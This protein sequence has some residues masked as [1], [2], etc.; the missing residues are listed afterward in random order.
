[1]DRD[2]L[3]AHFEWFA[4]WCV[5][6]SPLYE[7]LARGVAADPDLL[8]LAAETPEGRSPAHL[9]FAA[10][11]SLLLAGREA[12]LADYYPTVVADARD[13]DDGDP[14]AAFRECCLANADEIR[15]L[16]ATRRTQTNS[17]RRCT[18][19][20]PAFETVSR[21]ASRGRADCDSREPLALVEVGP[22]AGLNL[23]WDRYLYDY[24]PAGRYGDPESV[25][26]IESAVRAGDPPL[27]A[28]FPP[29]ASRVG[30]DVNPLDV[31]DEADARWL[32]ALVWPEHAERHRTLRRSLAAAREHPPDLREGDA[33]ELLPEVVAELPD[34]RPVCL[35]DTQVRYQL[36]DDERDRFDALVADLGA[37]RELYWVSGDAAADEYDQAIDLTLTTVD[38]GLRTERLGVYQQH[39]EWIAWD[40]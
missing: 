33:L 8:A 36:G 2:D 10:V 4:D 31:T 14:V 25:V 13:P 19:L 29:V 20:L 32:R 35:F 30:V 24:D 26:R 17:V 12:P 22:S 34:D 3:P 1:M 9:L 15:D 38:G 28:A 7:R 39:G 23:L 27:P 11:H 21:R 18:A 6:T 40:R 37:D 5:G 16:L